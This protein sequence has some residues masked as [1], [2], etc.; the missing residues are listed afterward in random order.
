MRV[1]TAAC[2]VWSAASLPSIAVIVPACSS[3]RRNADSRS[4]V[5]VTRCDTC[6]ATRSMPSRCRSTIAVFCVTSS[7]IALRTVSWWCTSG[8][9][10]AR[11]RSVV[12]ACSDEEARRSIESSLLA[13]V[14]NRWS[15]PSSRDVA[16]RCACTASSC[17]DRSRSM[18]SDRSRVRPVI[19]SASSRSAANSGRKVRKS[20]SSVRN[21]S[22]ESTFVSSSPHEVRMRLTSSPDAATR[23]ATASC[24]AANSAAT[25]CAAS[26]CFATSSICARLDSMRAM[27]SSSAANW[28]ARSI[29][30]SRVR[31]CSAARSA[32]VTRSSMAPK[33]YGEAAARDRSAVP[34]CGEEPLE[35]RLLNVEKSSIGSPPV[36]LS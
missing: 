3:C 7:V 22:A 19:A 2:W 31:S 10:R 28:A 30:V 12:N 34:E 9:P 23:S 29:V 27:R 26:A 33:S 16:C 36:F 25:S 15:I 6:A 14:W 13:V 11:L 8:T 17:T 21:S 4:E 24:D 32:R 20:S 35:D 18:V 1:S 5:R